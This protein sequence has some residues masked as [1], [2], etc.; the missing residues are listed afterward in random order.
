MNQKISPYGDFFMP[1]LSCYPHFAKQY[2]L[3]PSHKKRSFPWNCLRTI[4]PRSGRKWYEHWLKKGYF[5]SRPDDRPPFSV[6]IPPPNVTG[7]LHMGHTLNEAVQDILVHGKQGWRDT[8]PV[9][10]PVPVR[11][12]SHRG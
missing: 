12:Y 2:V 9:G 11:L 8:M 1:L 7:V 5:S 6:V 3:L 4:C 10:Y